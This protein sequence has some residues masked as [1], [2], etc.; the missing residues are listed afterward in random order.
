MFSCLP[1]L[2]FRVTG[3]YIANGLIIIIIKVEKQIHSPVDTLFQAS[4]GAFHARKQELYLYT[5]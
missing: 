2:R 5:V 4:S 1:L 3:F